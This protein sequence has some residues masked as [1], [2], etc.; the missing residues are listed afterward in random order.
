ML[1]S[2]PYP[3]VRRT[4]GVLSHVK[5]MF[6][7]R[8][9]RDTA[10]H[11]DLV[12]FRVC[13]AETD[14]QIAAERD[15]SAEALAAVKAARGEVQAEIV[16]NRAFLTSLEPLPVS[17]DATPL[18]KRMYETTAAAGVGPM[19]AVAGAVAEYVGDSL[20]PHSPQVIVENG[21]D[22]FLSTKTERIVS[23][24]A[25]SSSLSGRV[26]L[27]IPPDSRLGI[28][29]SSATVGH[30][31]SLGKADAGLIIAADGALADAVA[32]AFTNRIKSPATIQEALDWARTVPGVLQA[33]GIIGGTMGVWGEFELVTL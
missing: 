23:V 12:S 29:T 4:P 22:I 25:G 8:T 16:R 7:P 2:L 15:L 18:V 31:L 20:L 1:L 10:R 27:R 3:C 13:L 5:A 28:C 19:A 9:Y 30:S 21:G 6:Q 11:Q 17:A 33:L 32:T 24:H 26:G 14:L